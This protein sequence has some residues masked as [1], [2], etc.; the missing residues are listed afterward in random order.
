MGAGLRLAGY[1]PGPMSQ[2][3]GAMV[4]LLLVAASLYGCLLFSYLYL[5]TVAAE[6][7]P[8]ALP[9]LVH[10]GA[11]AAL[12]AASSALVALADRRVGRDGACGALVFAIPL[13]VAAQVLAF[14]AQ[15]AQYIPH[16]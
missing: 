14:R 11:I 1:A 8:R 15:H 4:V 13:L 6:S 9:P 2:A 16:K 7:W 3:W 10:A 12:L 5:W